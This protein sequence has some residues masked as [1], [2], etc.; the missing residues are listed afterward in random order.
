MASSAKNASAIRKMPDHIQARCNGAF[1]HAEKIAGRK[2]MH[3]PNIFHGAGN[4]KF[5]DRAARHKH[6][7]RGGQRALS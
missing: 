2:I 6:A 7:E 1:H 4:T 5:A 3:F